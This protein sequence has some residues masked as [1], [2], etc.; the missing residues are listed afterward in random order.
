MRE[1]GWAQLR[2]AR[3]MSYGIALQ[4]VAV[5]IALAIYFLP[6]IVADHRK[7]G[8]LLTIALFNACLGWTGLGWLIAIYWAYL[9][10]APAD[11]ARDVAIGRRKSRMRAF[12]E[13]LT[14][15]LERR[16]DRR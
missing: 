15:R 9:P 14:T 1:N 2:K 7:R 6:A 12:S 5:G 13:A 11:V 16:V 3:N 4:L 10:N 8:D